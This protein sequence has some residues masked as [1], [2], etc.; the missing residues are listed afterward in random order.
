MPVLCQLGWHLPQPLARWNDGYYFT[1]CR[2]CG[3]DLIRTLYGRWQIPRGFRVVWQSRPPKSHVSAQLVRDGGSRTSGTRRSNAPRSE[4]PIEEVLRHLQ[5][6]EQER[7]AVLR[8]PDGMQEPE[9]QAHLPSEPREA[10]IEAAGDPISDPPA[11]VEDSLAEAPAASEEQPEAEKPASAEAE[12][13]ADAGA[14]TEVEVEPAGTD[15]QAEA[16]AEAEAEAK[17]GT[18]TGLEAEV[19]AEA[20]VEDEAGQ[21][22]IEAGQVEV[23]GGPAAEEPAVEEPGDEQSADD[24][25]NGRRSVV[26]DFMSDGSPETDWLYDPPPPRIRAPVRVEPLPPPE[27]DP[28]PEPEPELVTETELEAP[29]EA[30]VEP[31]AAAAEPA[32]EEAEAEPSPP[33]TEAP[34]SVAP[35][36]ADR[37]KPHFA[38]LSGAAGEPRLGPIVRPGEKEQPSLTTTGML[39]AISLP[40]LFLIAVLLISRGPSADERPAPP[41]APGAPP[42]AAQPAFVTASLLNCRSAPAREARSV[43]RLARGDSVDIL[44]RDG[45]W[46]SIAAQGGQCWVLSRY[47]ST[48]RPA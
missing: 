5:G 9:P 47:I 2:R 24:E 6:Q 46:A 18:G 19:E 39:L 8:E 26:P 3:S 10:E 41:P 30:P 21:A 12:A 20:E 48:A 4:L 1:R 23:A 44:A 27:P 13:D 38:K 29:A 45:E 11:N 42:A 36:P 32:E 22:E 34:V 28:R 16:E 7:A 25:P 14:E 43:R 35:E 40:F 37:I 33:L 31:A 17:T 15:A